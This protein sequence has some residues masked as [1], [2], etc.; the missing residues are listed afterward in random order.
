[1]NTPEDKALPGVKVYAQWTDYNNKKKKGA[2]SPVYWTRSEADGK[3]AINIPE[4]T[5]AFGTVHTWEATAG[6]TLRV[7]AEN[8]DESKYTTAFV[9][10]D[11]TF[12]GQGDRYR[13]TWNGTVGVRVVEGFN[14]AFQERPEYDQ[15]FHPE[16]QWK[17]STRAGAG[18]HVKG[19]V[20]FEQ[21][22]TFGDVD[23][24]PRLE[25]RYGDIAVPNTKVVGA[26]VQDEV[27]RRFDAWKE[28]NPGY[29]R[30]DFKTA[31]REIMAAYEA[32]T[33]KSAIA[34]TVYDTTDSAGWYHLQFQGL[35]GNNY[36]SNG[37]GKHTHGD[38]V[39]E[40]DPNAAW[41][42]GQWHSRHINVQYMYVAPVL[43]NGVGGSL[44]N[45]RDNMFQSMTNDVT[46]ATD[47]AMDNIINVN[48]ALRMENRHFEVEKYN[49]TDKPAAPGDTASTK[50]TGFEANRGYDIVW[51]DS[52]GNEIKTCTS[53]ASNLGVVETCDLQV[54]EDLDA[55]QIYT[56]TIYPEGSRD[57]ALA[58][59]AFAAKVTPEYKKTIV[60]LDTQKTVEA[61]LNKEN[62][63]K[64]KDAK[65]SALTEEDII[66]KELL[67]G[68]DQTK[69]KVGSQPW[70]SVNSDGTI[71]LTPTR[72]AVEPGEYL[73]PVKVT[74]GSENDSY[75]KVI[76]API[77]VRDP[78]ADG[79]NDGTPDLKDQCPSVAGPASNNGCP[80]WGDGDGKPGADVTLE[81]DPANGPIP[82]SASCEAT[83]GATCVIGEDGNVVVKVP[84]D[85]KDKDEITVTIKDG[86]KTFDTSKVTV[87]DPDTDGDTVP[88]SLDRCPSVAGPA[89]NNGCPAWGDGDGKPG[90]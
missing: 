83:G 29:N 30:D 67:A 45:L 64:P 2:V 41:T 46:L 55:D 90:A 38:P 65:Y 82:G 1:M 70:A 36:W 68:V 15:M 62:G 75:E 22:G 57:A 50:A 17:K 8:P 43:P 4:W 10:G 21:R 74:I 52:N 53:T 76:L 85:A 23:A 47:G 87:T 9:E 56:A 79:D 88:D 5:D 80:A 14:I 7:W 48:Y 58:K 86:D 31:Q 42:K 78:N 34:E 51:T 66:P 32:E 73:V 37:I 69:V 71:T 19:R 33:G 12:G 6:Q 54:P 39:P 59:D 20:W 35:W 60:D 16:D 3:Y 24:V 77:T 26:Y 11:S 81:K 28:K 13:G 40:G 27:A 25:D 84:G 61:P 49:Q 44:N 89:S 63:T 72:D 18:G